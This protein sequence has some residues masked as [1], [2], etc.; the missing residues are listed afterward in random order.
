MRKLIVL[1][2]L[3]CFT[4]TVIGCKASGKVDDDGAKVKVD[5]K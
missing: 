1:G 2:L 4:A 3:L 5:T